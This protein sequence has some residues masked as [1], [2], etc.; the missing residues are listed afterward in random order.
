MSAEFS[1]C[2]PEFKY[3]DTHQRLAR[4]LTYIKVIWLFGANDLVVKRAS[5]VVNTALRRI[6]NINI[7]YRW[8]SLLFCLAARCSAS[9][10]LLRAAAPEGELTVTYCR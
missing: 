1:E 6:T 9:L 10:S 7:F 5:L 2:R 8:V 3:L 4:L